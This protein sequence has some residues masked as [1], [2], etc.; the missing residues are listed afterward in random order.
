MAHTPP[1]EG[2]PPVGTRFKMVVTDAKTKKVRE[3]IYELVEYVTLGQQ[4][5]KPATLGKLLL[6]QA[7]IEDREHLKICLKSL[8]VIDGLSVYDPSRPH[9]VLGRKGTHW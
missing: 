5:N 3:G 4:S 9:G 1:P 6:K 7:G 2:A 8:K